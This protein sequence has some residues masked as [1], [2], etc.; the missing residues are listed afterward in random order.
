MYCHIKAAH[1]PATSCFIEFL[2]IVTKQVANF[3]V[4]VLASRE[5]ILLRSHQ[6][7]CQ[8]EKL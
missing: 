7:H 4:D 2:Y 5:L 8:K 6:L 1:K 3:I